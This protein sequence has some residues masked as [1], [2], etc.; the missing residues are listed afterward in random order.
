MR[1]MVLA[2]IVFLLAIG[3]ATFVEAIYDIQTAKLFI[4]NATWFNILLL[5]LSLIL[6]VNIFR[7]KMF[8]RSKIAM[9]S[10]H[11]SFLIIMIG[12][13]I[14]RF[15]S[16]EGL[17]LIREGQASNFI[18]S[19]DPMLYY[20]LN[21]GKMQLENTEKMF[22]SEQAWSYP[23]TTLKFP[24]HKNKIRM[25]VIGFRKRMVDSLIIDPKFTDEVLEIVTGGMTSN[26]L[27]RDSFIIL[28]P[29]AGAMGGLSL[30]FEHESPVPGITVKQ[31]GGRL[32]LKTKIPM[33]A[34][35]M[36]Q[37]TKYRQSG[38]T[39]PDS[40][41]KY[42]PVDTLVPF[43][44]TTLYQVG[45][46]QF[47]FKSRIKNAKMM[48]MPSGK[49][50]VGMDILT[51]KITDGEQSKIVNIEGGMGV[52]PTEEIFT[53]AGLDYQIAY[54]S[55]RI[56]LP[57][58]VF[59]KDF[60]IDK[61][62]GSNSPSSFAS[63]VQIQDEKNNYV[64][65]QRIFMNNVMDYKGYRFFQSSYDPDEKGTRLSVNYDFWGTNVTYVGYLLMAI[66]MI[67]SL[68]SPVGRF[69]ELIQ[70]L[71]K[72]AERKKA[73]TT[74]VLLAALFFNQT[75]IAQTISSNPNVQQEQED[76]S[77]HNHAPGEHNQE[78][79]SG[80]DHA[81]GEHDHEDHSGH[82][83]APGEHDHSSHEAHA[84]DNAIE[85]I[86]KEIYKGEL[87]VMSKEHSEKLSNLIVQDYQGR[88]APFHTVATDIM[89]KIHRGD[90]YKDYDAIQVVMSAQMY[91]NQWFEEPIFYIS[92]KIKDS[93][94]LGKYASFRQLVN[95]SGEFKWTAEYDEAFRT[96]ES[97]RDEFKKNIIK[98]MD[99]VQVMHALI[100]WQ[101]FKVL[102]VA[103]DPTDT[104]HNP[105]EMNLTDKESLSLGISYINK[106]DNAIRGG[107]YTEAD[108]LLNDLK[109]LQRS[110]SSDILPSQTKIDLEVSYNKMDIFKNVQNSYLL[111]GFI[112]LCIWFARIFTLPRKRTEKIF[113]NIGR[114]F[115]FIFAAIFIYHGI[116]IGFRWYIS[117]H[118]PWSNGYEALVFISWVTVLAGISFSRR[119][120]VILAVTAIL[121]FFFLFV[122]SMN[123]LDPAI[124]PLQPVLQSYW[125]M[126]HVAIITGSYGFLGL[127][128]ILGLLNL[129]LYTTRNRENGK[130]VTLNINELTYIS[131]MTMTIGLF[132]LTIGTFLGGIWANESWGRYWGW[133]PKETWALVSVLVYA[134]ILHLRYIPGLKGK[135]LFNA[136]S[137]WGYSAILFTFFG[138][139]FVLVGLHSYAQGDGLAK[140]PEWLI[141]VIIGFAI[142][143]TWAAIR[144]KKYKT[145]ISKGDDDI[146]RL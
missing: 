40:V 129:V 119:N 127:G 17:M 89:N 53:F 50:D 100:A 86:P 2:L 97:E 138:V 73:M 46:E 71:E 94:K 66:G 137:F 72:I 128:F 115:T 19:T 99:H 44:S 58:S 27:S 118:A 64:R 30:S 85:F 93:L 7:Y 96:K 22:M 116:G 26:Y 142:F 88:F 91:A 81:P 14:T 33:R 24:N 13:A 28:N 34:L 32:F 103:N 90:T 38:M 59:C 52:I 31:N 9:L 57:F 6:I 21:D 37:M 131:E 111:T 55:T 101:Y 120:K 80:H 122:A 132:M 4:Y 105:L 1:M 98:L 78:D 82:D 74:M 51:L 54:G 41:F 139:N 135:F 67:L 16:F 45:E 109:K 123:I 106:L 60:Q 75:T 141:Y 140:F 36:A 69:G 20:K 83:H 121:A 35:P 29:E 107:K 133:D 77:G 124:S 42:I 104:W 84:H 114:I 25:E 39:P 125:L 87:S 70:K 5:Y 61:Y 12:A 8:Q 11:L 144:N 76:H 47:V 68:F 134:T 79:H 62:P 126:I 23:S 15:Y 113:N 102:P 130:L 108:K 110:K 18:Y 143:T 48:K 136:V 3:A 63:E 92:P 146:V 10:F 95:P 43:E 112:L 65:D 56:Q 117:G 145:L 49:K